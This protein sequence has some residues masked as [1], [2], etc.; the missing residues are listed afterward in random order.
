MI[1]YDLLKFCFG[2]VD[3]HREFGGSEEIIVLLYA[4]TDRVILKVENG[5]L[6]VHAGVNSLSQLNRFIYIFCVKFPINMLTG[7]LEL[8]DAVYQQHQI[9]MVSIVVIS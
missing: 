6:V 1:F 4:I 7:I 9:E 2:I 5:M 3:V 8:L